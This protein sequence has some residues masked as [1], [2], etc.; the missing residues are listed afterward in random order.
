MDAVMT[1]TGDL[2]RS[3]DHDK[4]ETQEKHREEFPSRINQDGDD[5]R[6]IRQA[7]ATFIDPLD[8]ESHGGRS[9]LNIVSGE[10]ADPEVNVDNSI[11]LGKVMLTEFES[12]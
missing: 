11:D 8:P 3:G 1:L 5:R 6:A 9:L 4:K 2:K 10:V 7:L 12:S